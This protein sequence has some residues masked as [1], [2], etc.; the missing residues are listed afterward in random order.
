MTPTPKVPPTLAYLRAMRDD[1][2]ALA[3]AHNVEDIRIVGSVARGEA[4]LDS[5]IDFLLSISPRSVFDL[6][7]LWLDLR[8]LLGYEIS[9]IPY[10]AKNPDF[11]RSVLDDAVEL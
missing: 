5:D 4:T 6:V 3:R 9:V 10:N 8:E 7:G 2:L 1:I 11:M